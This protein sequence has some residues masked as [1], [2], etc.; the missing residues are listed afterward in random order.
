MRGQANKFDSFHPREYDRPTS[1]FDKFPVAN[2]F[3]EPFQRRGGQ[4]SHDAILLSFKRN[5]AELGQGQGEGEGEGQ[6]QGQGQLPDRWKVG[7]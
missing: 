4:S 1:S 5:Q 3:V 6:G 7:P 2:S